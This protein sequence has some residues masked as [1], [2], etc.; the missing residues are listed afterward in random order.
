MN[1]Q[2]IDSSTDSFEVGL[3]S[4]KIIGWS[5]VIFFAGCSIGAFMSKQYGPISVF[6]FFILM[7]TYMIL[8]GG[9]F[10]LNSQAITHHNI[11]G[12]YRLPWNEIEQIEVGIA[13]D[14]IVLHGANKRFV[15]APPSMW[16]GSKKTAAFALLQKKLESIGITPYPS[17]TAAYKVHKNVRV[18]NQHI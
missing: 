9:H 11:F 5:C 2:Q 1:N 17:N 15:V 12:T 10:S 7:G 6:A 18:K 3:L 16:S 14:T 8:A 4:Y 13:D